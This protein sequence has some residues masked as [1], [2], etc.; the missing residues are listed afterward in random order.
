MIIRQNHS[1]GQSV[2]FII[3]VEM[4][5]FIHSSSSPKKMYRP[6]DAQLVS[7]ILFAHFIE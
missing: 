6:F 3:E 4:F 1:L 5:F 2:P 7:V